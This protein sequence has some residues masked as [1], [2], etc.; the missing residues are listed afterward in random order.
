VFSK[1][2]HAKAIAVRVLQHLAVDV[3][4]SSIILV[5]SVDIALGLVKEFDYFI[6]GASLRFE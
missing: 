6:V 3:F 4:T 1:L 5:S 2:G